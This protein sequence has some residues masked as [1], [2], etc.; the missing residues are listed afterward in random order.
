ML[1]INQLFD[2]QGNFAGTFKVKAVITLDDSGNTFTSKF[3]FWVFDPDGNEVF[4][5]TGTAS[6][7]RVSL[8]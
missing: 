6:G 4:Q 3:N 1:E 8:D 2:G 5:G 7:R